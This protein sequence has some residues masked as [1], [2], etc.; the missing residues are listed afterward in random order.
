[1]RPLLLPFLLQTLTACATM[2]AEPENLV[3][4]PTYH[5]FGIPSWGV[6]IGDDI[7]LRLGHDH[8]DSE[9]LVAAE[10][11][12]PAVLARHHGDVRRWRSG[13]SRGILVEVRP[14]PCTTP[15]GQVLPDHVRVVHPKGEWQGCGEPWSGDNLQ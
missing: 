5:A 2:S 8:F 1:M 11:R 15:G 10:Y 14:G 6:E 7:V 4:S 9:S 13:G 3:D 12:Y